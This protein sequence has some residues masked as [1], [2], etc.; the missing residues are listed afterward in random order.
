MKISVVTPTYNRNFC[1]ENLYYSLKKQTYVDFEWMII[2]DGSTDDTKEKILSFKNENQIKIKYYYQENQGKFSA[3]NKAIELASGDLFFI[4]DSD[5]YLSND[6]L[7]KIVKWS[8]DIY[9]DNNFIGIAGLKA[10]KNRDTIGTSH[11]EAY[12]DATSA[13]YRYKYKIKGDKAEV[14]FTKRLKNYKFPKIE[15]IKNF[16]TEAI[17]FNQMSMDKKKIRW[18]NEII[19][20]TEYLDDGLSKNILEHKYKNWNSYVYYYNQILKMDIPIIEKVREISNYYRFGFNI[21]NTKELNNDLD[22]NK[23]NFICNFIGKIYFYKDK[24]REKNV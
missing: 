14:F 10:Y 4:V 1:I 7:E 11:K 9:E 19:Y 8:K 16:Q 23:I 22:K 6:A 17:L 12:L 24:L 13:E 18:F 20:F 3:I 21:K 15:N 5:D 2:D